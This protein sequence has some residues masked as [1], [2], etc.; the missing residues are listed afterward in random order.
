MQFLFDLDG[1][2]TTKEILPL[3]AR[4]LGI[5]TKM[6]DLTRKTM[7]GEIPFEH[8]FTMR[9][10]MLKTVP[11]SRVQ[12]IVSQI[13]LSSVVLKFIRSHK[14]QC[15]VVT[16]NLDVWIAPLVKKLQTPFY[17]SSALSS[18]DSLTGIHTILRKKDVHHQIRGKTVAIGDGNND[19]E[20]LDHASIAIAYGGVHDPAPSLL[21][22]AD[23]AIYSEER[24]CSLLNRLS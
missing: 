16:G 23:Y 1:T 2:I 20:M 5:E 19:F 15:S 4:E 10:N 8:S 3:I 22:I 7:S 6:A 18:G 13:P 17:C 21:E 11:I 24:L 14:T 12:Q 9:V